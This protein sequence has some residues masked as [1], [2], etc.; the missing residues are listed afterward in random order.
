MWACSLAH[1]YSYIYLSM[2]LT[3]HYSQNETA[4]GHSEARVQLEARIRS[5]EARLAVIGMGY[6][7]LPLAV[8]FAEAGVPVTG[9][10]VSAP[11]MDQLNGGD[12]YIED[13]ATDRLHP[14]VEAGM[15]QGRPT[16]RCWP[17]WT[18]LASV[19]PRR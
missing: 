11:R 14:L 16:S 9:I 7:G 13:I 17:R 3:N 4:E 18:P 12:S 15:L 8:V 2:N 5:G 6:V 19:Y 10:D 1:T